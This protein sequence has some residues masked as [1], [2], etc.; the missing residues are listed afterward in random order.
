MKDPYADL[1]EE[2]KNLHFQ[3]VNQYQ[4]KLRRKPVLKNLF[5]EMTIRCNAHCLHCG[6]SCGDI[7]ENNP[8]SDHEILRVLI[9][10]KDDIKKDGLPLPFISVTG[11]EPLMRKDLTSLMKTIHALGYN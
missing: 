1:S 9:R 2:E 7:K 11:G 5:I 8:L 4:N 10:L 3:Q 6:S